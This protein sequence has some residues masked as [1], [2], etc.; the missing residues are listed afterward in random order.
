LLHDINGMLHRY[1]RM[2]HDVAVRTARR[3]PLDL[4]LRVCAQPGHLRGD[5]K[6][7]LL[8]VFSNRALTGGRRGLFHPDSLTFG[9]SIYLSRLVAA[10]QTVVGVES[11]QVTKLQRLFEAPNH[12]IERGVLAL[13]P[14]EVA[15]LDN[16]PSFPEHGRLAI[17]MK[18]GR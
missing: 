3:V 5:V 4:A 7:A 14:F 15:Q 12:E 11:V 8:E 13:G 10:A 9:Q 16:D 1:R 17:E 18:G 6:A 2:G